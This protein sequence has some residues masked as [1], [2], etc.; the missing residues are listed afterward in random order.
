M[1][2]RWCRSDWM[3]VPRNQFCQE[4]QHEIDI[5]QGE[6]TPPERYS[7]SMAMQVRRV[8]SNLVAARSRR[9]GAGRRRETSRQAVSAGARRRIAPGGASQL[10]DTAPISAPRRR[11]ELTREEIAKKEEF[12]WQINK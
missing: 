11:A 4:N 10:A 1:R 12:R 9:C 5:R 2:N 3:I 8:A 6:T 7:K